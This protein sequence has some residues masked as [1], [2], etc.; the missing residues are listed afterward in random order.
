MFLFLEQL[1]KGKGKVIEKR[2][3]LQELIEH[4]IKYKQQHCGFLLVYAAAIFPIFLS[5]SWALMC[6]SKFIV[7]EPKYKKEKEIQCLYEI[8]WLYFFTLGQQHIS[9]L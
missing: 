8:C 3:L 2:T 6:F 5:V 4:R 1:L 9:W 7:D